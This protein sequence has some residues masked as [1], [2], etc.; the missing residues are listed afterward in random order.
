MKKKIFRCYQEKLMLDLQ[1]QE[2]ASAYLSQALLDED[3][4]V[5]LLALKNVWDSRS[6]CSHIKSKKLS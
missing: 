1:D 6:Q 2:L 4:R 3:P 5:F